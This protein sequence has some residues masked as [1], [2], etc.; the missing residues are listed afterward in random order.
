MVKD[1]KVGFKEAGRVP[2]EILKDGKYI[3]HVIM[4]LEL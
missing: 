3:D 2:K 1:R 4:T